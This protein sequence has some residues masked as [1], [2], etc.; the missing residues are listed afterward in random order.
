VQKLKTSG[1]TVIEAVQA[2]PTA[3]LD[4]TWGNGFTQ[5]NMFV[6]IVYATL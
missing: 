5:P 6:G 2:K 4:S 1:K 3:D